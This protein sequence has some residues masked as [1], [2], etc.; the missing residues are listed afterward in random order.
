MEIEKRQVLLATEAEAY[1]EALQKFEL[2][3]I[4]SP[5][6]FQQHEYLGKLTMQ[7]VLSASGQEDEF[8]KEFFLVMGKVPLVIHEL[9]AVETWKEKI[10]PEFVKL[11]F[12]PSTSVPLYMVLYQEAILVTLLE[13]ILY[14]QEVL[15]SGEDYILD[16][17]GYCHRKLTDL[18]SGNYNP[19]K[20][21]KEK[22]SDISRTLIDDLQRHKKSMGFDIA[23]KTVS[24]LRYIAENLSSLPLSVTHHILSVH[25][26]PLLLSFLLEEPPWVRCS[27]NSEEKYIDGKWCLVEEENRFQITKIEGQVWITLYILLLSEECQKKYELNSYKK[28]QIL[29]LRSHLSEILIEQL[30]SLQ[31]LQ[32]YLESLSIMEPPAVRRDLIIEQISEL[33]EEFLKEG[34]GKWDKISRQQAETF[35]SPSLEALKEHS[36]RLADTYSVDILENFVPETPK[37]CVCGHSANKRCSR[38]RNEWYCRRE[39]QVQHWP[40]HKVA[41]SLVT[42]SES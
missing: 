7:A 32:Q 38:C 37:C 2:E 30:P 4:G 11:K 23:M 3:N 16:L 22:E 31:S 10:F 36:R 19:E 5:R 28:N 39:C 21:V 29:K 15:E 6:W 25:D 26:F 9:I 27:D 33:R 41:C 20:D 40:K 13:I 14:H 34:E 17:L 8:I 18:L 42:N 24:I 12:K 35:F 1:I